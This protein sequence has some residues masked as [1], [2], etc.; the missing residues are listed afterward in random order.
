MTRGLRINNPPT[1]VAEEEEDTIPDMMARTVEGR[2]DTVEG[3]EALLH[4]E[5]VRRTAAAGLIIK[6][7]REGDMGMA[8]TMVDTTSPHRHR[9]AVIAEVVTTEAVVINLVEATNQAEAISPVEVINLVDHT[10]PVSSLTG[11]KEDTTKEVE[12]VG[13]GTD[14]RRRRTY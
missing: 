1:E 6:E 13:E 5:E 2:M 4:I 7:V 10:A 8:A 11:A 9:T 3:A 12:V 14:H